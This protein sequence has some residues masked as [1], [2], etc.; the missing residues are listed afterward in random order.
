MNPDQDTEEILIVDD[1]AA[2]LR[3]LCDTLLAQGLKVTGFTS[4]RAALD[5]LR[6]RRTFALVL[7]DLMM[8]EMDGI[9][10]L[11]AALE[12]DPR[13][14]GVV[15]TGHG[16]IDTAVAAMKQGALDY[17]LKPFK[18]STLVPVLSRALNVRRLRL[19]NETLQRRLRVRTSELEA[20]NKELEAFSYSVSHDLSA[21]LRAVTGFTDLLVESLGDRLSAEERGY[22]DTVRGGVR[23]MDDLITN[24]LRLAQTTRTEVNRVSI[25]LSREVRDIA[26]RLRADSPD[27]RVECV[28]APDVV[29]E[30]DVG[31]LRVVLQNLLSNAWKYTGKTERALIEFGVVTQ[32]DGTRACFVRDNGAGFDMK[33]AHRLFGPFQRLHAHS[34]FPGTGVGLATVQRIIHKHGGR[35]WAESS[36]GRGATFY[37]TLPE[38]AG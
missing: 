4:A 30:G 36:P 12:I 20:A 11:R 18:L 29:G 15:M 17:I 27:R 22:A 2:H 8:P 1:E 28:I 9:A 34:D 37:F 16:T 6:E 23:R 14:V 10:L 31:L 35:I 25:D 32:A 38:A 5:V 13:L 19:E 7:T 26:D 21:P 33:Q 3:A 24:L